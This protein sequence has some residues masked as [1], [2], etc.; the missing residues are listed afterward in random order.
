MNRVYDNT[1]AEVDVSTL[2]VS[3]VDHSDFPDYVDAEFSFGTGV[4]GIDLDAL[5]LEGLTESY[6]SLL[7]DI[8]YDLWVDRCDGEIA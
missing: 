4:D 7:Q 3:H 2:E 5:E 8:C 1:G 6:P